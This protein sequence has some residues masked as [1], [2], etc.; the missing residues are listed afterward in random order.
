MT[1]TINGEAID[2]AVLDSEFAGIKSYFES[3]GNVSCCER[4]GEFRGYAKQNVVSRVLLVQEAKRRLEPIPQDEV[5]T[6]FQNLIAEHGGEMQFYAG[7][8]AGP[9][10]AD[11]IKR[12]MELNLRVQKM[13]REVCP[14]DEPSDAELAEYYNQ[15]LARYMTEEQAKASHILKAPKRGED[16]RG[17]YEQ[18]RRVR[19]ELIGGADFDALAK[20]HSDK[21]DEQIDLGWFKR[22]ELP[23]EFEL[24]AFSMN[25]GEVSPVFGSPFGYHVL[26]CTGLDPAVPRPFE[27]VRDAARATLME[28]RRNEKMR[29]LVKQL[30]ESAKIED[31]APAEPAPAHAHST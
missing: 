14:V 15:N 5:D 17:A 27:E 26:K 7:I 6:A 1:L 22:G 23:E 2:P 13:V 10:Q 21:R 29:E 19:R 28:D 24:V 11:L 25:V 31:D 8:G 16:R 30:Q 3:L 20:E 4:D 12:D 9:D 18:L